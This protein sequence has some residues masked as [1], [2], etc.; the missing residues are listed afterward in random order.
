MDNK[1]RK[2]ISFDMNN[3]KHRMCYEFLHFIPRKNVDFISDLVC[4]YLQM[5]GITDVSSL[6]KEE[7]TKL[8]SAA[9]YRINNYSESMLMQNNLYLQQ[10]ATSL[11]SPNNRV[12][13]SDNP[14]MK[15]DEYQTSSLS[16]NGQI[17]DNEIDEVK[18]SNDEPEPENDDDYIN[19]GLASSLD[20]F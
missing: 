7:A 6:T 5:N 14:S 1:I 20:M 13:L 3:K 18:Q 8:M 19:S 10:L 12:V 11:S 17:E 15:E 16:Q 4:A 2:H 9:E